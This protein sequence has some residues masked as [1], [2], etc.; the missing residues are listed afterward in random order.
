MESS[1]GKEQLRL[2]RLLQLV[3]K[4]SVNFPPA[5]GV[6]TEARSSSITCCPFQMEDF[7]DHFVITQ[8]CRRGAGLLPTAI[9][10]FS[11]T[12]QLI[13][14]LFSAFL[15]AVKG[16]LVSIRNLIFRGA[17][18]HPFYTPNHPPHTH[19]HTFSIKSID[20]DCQ[21]FYFYPL[22][23]LSPAAGMEA[24]NLKSGER[25]ASPP[26]LWLPKRTGSV[27]CTFYLCIKIFLKMDNLNFAGVQAS[28]QSTGS[29]RLTTIPLGTVCCNGPGEK[30]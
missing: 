5:K 18:I 15:Y 21:R 26:S 16:Q 6:Q 17:V 11:L 13:F 4:E 30:K 24:Q 2:A 10:Y 27:L 7:R 22:L 12:E 14:W 8:K 28:I 20:S 29:S 3:V 9:F 25:V 19:T 23:Q 1:G